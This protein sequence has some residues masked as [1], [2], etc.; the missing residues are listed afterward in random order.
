[1]SIL[2][3]VLHRFIIELF[4]LSRVVVIT[5]ILERLSSQDFVQELSEN[6]LRRFF[7]TPRSRATIYEQLLARFDEQVPD[8]ERHLY[9]ATNIIQLLID[10]IL[11]Q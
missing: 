7:I 9:L 10:V 3:L 2:L 4:F 6:I 1:M 11:D 5:M 8:H